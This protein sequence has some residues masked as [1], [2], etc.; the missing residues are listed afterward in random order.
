MGQID[1]VRELINEMRQIDSE[2]EHWEGTLCLGYA[3]KR[4]NEYDLAVKFNQK[5]IQQAPKSFWTYFKF[6]E[7]HQDLQDYKSFFK[8]LD[9]SI[10]KGMYYNEVGKHFYFHI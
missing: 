5:A 7:I 3:H 2:V 8:D 4:L 1:K 10:S 6:A 9:T